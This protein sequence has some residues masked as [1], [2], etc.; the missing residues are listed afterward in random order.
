MFVSVDHDLYTRT[1]DIPRCGVDNLD[2]YLLSDVENGLAS[3][4][5]P[6]P[7]R[8]KDYCR[9]C[10]VDHCIHCFYCLGEEGKDDSD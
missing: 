9:L 8:K 5:R 7:G 1:V 6:K 4:F 2:S 3:L 10:K